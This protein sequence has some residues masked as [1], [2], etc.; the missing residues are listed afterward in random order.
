MKTEREYFNGRN[1]SCALPQ[2]SEILNNIIIFAFM[3]GM[4]VS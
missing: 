3:D 2:N 1:Y 4:K